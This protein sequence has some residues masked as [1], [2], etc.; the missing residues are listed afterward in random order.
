MTTGLATIAPRLAKLLLMLS[1]SRDGEVLNAARLITNTL[2]NSGA[3]WHDLAANLT[4]PPTKTQ[5][6]KQRDD[7]DSGDRDWRA[8]R[9]FCEK[10][11]DFLNVREKEFIADIEHWRGELTQKQQHWLCSIYARLQRRAA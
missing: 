11:S 6:K 2:K 1:S 7:D 4:A 9:T 3:D 8:M 5:T 10:R